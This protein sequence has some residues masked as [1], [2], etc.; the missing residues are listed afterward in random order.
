MGQEFTQSA[1]AAEKQAGNRLLGP[2]ELRCDLRDPLSITES[3]TEVFDRGPLPEDL[4]RDGGAWIN[5]TN[6]VLESMT[7]SLERLE[8]ISAE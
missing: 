8:K 3:V 1:S 4:L 2:S 6:S 7:A 5:G